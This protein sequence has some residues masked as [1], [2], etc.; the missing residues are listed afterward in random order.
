MQLRGKVAIITGAGTG[1]GKATAIVFAR[2]GARIATI[3]RRPEKLADVEREVRAAGSEL[4]PFQGDVSKPEDVHELVRRTVERFKGV[5]ILINN[6]GIHAKPRLTHEVPLEEFDAFINTNLR[7]PFLLMREVI[8]IMLTRGGG[9]IINIASEVG[10]VGVKYCVSYGTVKGA[11]INMTR[12]VALDYADKGIRVNCVPVGGMS[13]TENTLHFTT[14]ERAK[15]KEGMPRRPTGKQSAAS[16]V[17]EMLLF[18][19]GPY[20]TNITGAVF[21]HDGGSTAH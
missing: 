14:E 13:G 8:P 3:G 12:T 16:D 11:M 15:M 1:L 5:D 9:S 7:G 19:A 6:A 18:L 21:S 4:L 17:A 2:E 20:A 10:M